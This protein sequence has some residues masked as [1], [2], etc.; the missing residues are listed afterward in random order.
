MT[1]SSLLALISWL[2]LNS[3]GLASERYQSHESISASIRLFLESNFRQHTPDYVIELVPIDNRLRLT[4]CERA[5][6][7]FLLPGS[8]QTGYLSVG[9]RCA[10][11]QPWTI[12]SQARVKQF[13]GVVVLR[14]A[15]RVGSVISANDIE[16][17]RR[18]IS[19]LHAGYL[20]SADQAVNKQL[21]RAGA[22]GSVLSAS[23][24]NE[25]KL[26][27][28]GQKVIVRTQIGSLDVNSRGEALM[29]GQAGQRV[30]VRNEQSGRII[31]GLVVG[32]GEVRIP[33]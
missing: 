13:K 33:F 3:A 26:I 7:V 6:E 20:T 5:L 8:R 32:S 30:R 10:G 27:K 24:L 4:L 31:E 21:K 28:R 16:M 22:P 25:I 9:V 17:D 29:D 18:E 1:R 2:A 14:N 12:Y 19:Q 23:Q 11:N 15:L